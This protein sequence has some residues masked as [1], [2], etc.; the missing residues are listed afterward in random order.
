M[1][2]SYW[3]R[4]PG[5]P[6]IYSGE[7]DL[8]FMAGMTRRGAWGA[9]RGARWGGTRVFCDGANDLAEARTIATT[10]ARIFRLVAVGSCQA[11]SCQAGR[12]GFV[13]GWFVASCPAPP[14]VRPGRLGR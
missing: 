5:G 1:S 6:R 8:V 12:R 13:L 11:G 2:F 7:S 3:E 9:R 10:K 4:K 14:W